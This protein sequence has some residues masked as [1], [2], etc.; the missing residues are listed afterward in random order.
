[1]GGIYYAAFVLHSGSVWPAVV[2]HVVLN[3]VVGA[4]AV[5]NPEFAETVSGWLL[6]LALQLPAVVLGMVLILRVQPRPIVPA[7]A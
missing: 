2:L 7:A 3:A 6:V 4:Q 5:G 1:L